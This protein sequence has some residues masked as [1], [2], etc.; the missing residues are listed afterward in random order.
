M[1]GA[2]KLANAVRKKEFMLV[3]KLVARVIA[4]PRAVHIE[5]ALDHLAA[6]LELAP[7]ANATLQLVS[8][9]RLTRTG[10]AVRLVHSSGKAATAGTPDPGLV[11]LLLKARE[12]SVRPTWQAG[13]SAGSGCG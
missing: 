10:M 4:M 6:S 12:G 1:V 5:L 9:V 3:R 13:H 2:E 11:K 7:P 8:P